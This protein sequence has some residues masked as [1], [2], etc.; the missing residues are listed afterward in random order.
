MLTLYCAELQAAAASQRTIKRAINMKSVRI[1]AGPLSE[2][3]CV[4]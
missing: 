3:K 1:A 4:L 2:F